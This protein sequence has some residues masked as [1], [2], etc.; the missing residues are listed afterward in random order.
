MERYSVLRRSEF[1][2]WGPEEK[3]EYYKKHRST[4]DQRWVR[5]AS[6]GV[7]DN[8]NLNQHCR[9]YF[10]KPGLRTSYRLRQLDAPHDKFSQS[11]DSFRKMSRFS[12]S[13]NVLRP[14]AQRQASDPTSSTSCGTTRASAKSACRN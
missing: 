13:T 1:V 7:E 3:E 11:C 12:T 4:W 6:L 8:K 14:F 10:A 9:H 2:G 5:Y